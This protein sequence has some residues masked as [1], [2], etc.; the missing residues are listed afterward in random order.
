MVLVNLLKLVVLS[1]AFTASETY[2]SARV[3]KPKA[4]LVPEKGVFIQNFFQIWFECID[5][6]EYLRGLK[7]GKEKVLKE[8]T[9]S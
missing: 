8:M 5:E 4:P 9:L 2:P 6:E 7:E 3:L 1:Q